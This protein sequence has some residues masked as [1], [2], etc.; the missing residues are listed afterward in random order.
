MCK[1]VSQSYSSQQIINLNKYQTKT[2]YYNVVKIPKGAV[3]VEIVQ[4]G[5]LGDGNYL[6]E[7]YIANVKW[8]FFLSIWWFF[9]RFAVEEDNHG[10][11]LGFGNPF[12]TEEATLDFGGLYFKYISNR[13][14]VKVTSPPSKHLRRD[15]NIKV[16]QKL[17][18][19]FMSACQILQFIFDRF[20]WIHDNMEIFQFAFLIGLECKW[21]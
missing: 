20:T 13:N 10:K 17:T 4:T 15:M 11:L 7:I 2:Y 14:M 5:H 18:I 19:I 8:E 1:R 12:S 21:I 9:Y 6:G 16:C 3:N